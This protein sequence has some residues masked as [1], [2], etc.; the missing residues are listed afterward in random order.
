MYTGIGV[1]LIFTVTLSEDYKF[2][3]YYQQT[4]AKKYE[5]AI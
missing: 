3:T 2:N 1:Y 4:Q 5:I